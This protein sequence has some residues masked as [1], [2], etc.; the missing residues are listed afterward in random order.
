MGRPSKL[1]DEL[2]Q[3]ICLLLA[4]GKR[5]DVACAEVGIDPSTLTHWKRAAQQGDARCAEF[6]T[7]I[8]RAKLLGEGHL[9]DVVKRGDEKGVSNG[10][11]K[12]AQ[13]LLERTRPNRYAPR[14][15]VKLEEGL[16]ALLSDV[17]R[18]CGSKDCGCYEAILAALAARADGDGA[19]PE[20]PGEGADSP[21]H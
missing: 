14:L 21:I 7:A 19:P 1:T 3:K 11:S 2:Q 8:A 17:E 9:F 18:V 15:N 16:E 20:D 4:E 5:V 10:T 13:W 6:L 12:S